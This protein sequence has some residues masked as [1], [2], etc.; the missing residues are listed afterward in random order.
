ME[1]VL[2]QK[3]VYSW[4]DAV[5]R[6]LHESA[7]KRS[8]ETDKV[9]LRWL[10]KYLHNVELHKINRDLLETIANAKAAEGVTLGRVPKV[11]FQ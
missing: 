9:T 2:E 5:L 10:D 8:I 3:P 6:W 7:S 4:Q 1:A 11:Y